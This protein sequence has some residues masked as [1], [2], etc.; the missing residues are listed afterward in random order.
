M[1]CTLGLVIPTSA[2]SV[3]KL[4]RRVGENRHIQYES[5]GRLGKC[6]RN[7]K[8]FI[9]VTKLYDS[10]MRQSSVLPTTKTAAGQEQPLDRAL[11]S[12]SV[13]ALK[14]YNCYSSAHCYLQIVYISR[15]LMQSKNVI[16]IARSQYVFPGLLQPMC[17][18]NWYQFP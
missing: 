10:L 7:R 5:E 9:R 4:S 17:R 18:K 2:M 15:I 13:Y 12:A 1:P 3:S 6:N 11:Q 14:F 16:K 8:R